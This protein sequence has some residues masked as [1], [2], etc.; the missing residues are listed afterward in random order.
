MPIERVT[1]E[2]G[3]VQKVT[4]HENGV[5]VVVREP[6]LKIVTLGIQGP[7]GAQGIQGLPGPQ[8]I[9]GEDGSG[10]LTYIHNQ[11]VPSTLWIINHN[12]GKRP[13]VRVV[14]SGDNVVVGHVHDIDDN[15]LQIEFSVIFGGK[16][17]LN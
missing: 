15:N 3:G 10:D 13:S 6:E 16:A 17:Y 5:K 8:G 9:P 4:V 2:E 11:S 1:I 14:D 7:S 12:L